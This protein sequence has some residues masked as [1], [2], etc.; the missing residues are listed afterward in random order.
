MDLLKNIADSVTKAVDYV[1][2]RNRKTA[3]INRLRIVIKNEK[4]KQLR[5]YAELGKYYYE[6]MR[7]KNNEETEKSC[8][9]IEN[10]SRRLSRAVTKLDEITASECENGGGETGDAG[11]TGENREAGESCGC[12]CTCE[13]GEPAGTGAEE[14]CCGEY[15]AEGKTEK[16]GSF[17]DSG[18]YGETAP[19]SKPDTACDDFANF[20]KEA[21]QEDAEETGEE[22]ADDG[23][24]PFKP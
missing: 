20:G 16:H 23:N 6:H 12:G 19:E 1:V 13:S 9:V 14:P 8:A 18:D 3:M 10:S 2:D 21:A 24:P 22:A 17:D 15:C 5:A 11:E 7:D 4:E